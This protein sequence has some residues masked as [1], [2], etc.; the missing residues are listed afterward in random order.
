VA[1]RTAQA[2][3]QHRIVFHHQDAHRSPLRNRVR[4]A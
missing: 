2:V 3:A 4:L 1:K